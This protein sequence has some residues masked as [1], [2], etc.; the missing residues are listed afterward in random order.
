[1]IPVKCFAAMGWMPRGTGPGDVPSSICN[2]PAERWFLMQ[3]IGRAGAST[4]MAGYCGE[5][6]AKLNVME[7][8]FSQE[9]TYDEACVW[10]VHRS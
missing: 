3:D 2:R 1:M 4:F 10:E 7:L 9:L 5:H 6:A 8:E